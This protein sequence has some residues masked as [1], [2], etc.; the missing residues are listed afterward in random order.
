[1]RKKQRRL[2]V[3]GAGP[4]G[5]L[6][7]HAATQRGYEPIIFSNADENGQPLKSKLYG[8]QYL[9]QPIEGITAPGERVWVHYELRGS[10]EAYRRKVYGPGFQGSVSPD[11]YGPEKPHAAY[12]IRKTY[13][14]LWEMYQGRIEPATV[15]ADMA[16]RLVRDHYC[17]VLST[18]P[19]QPMCRNVA[20]I[21]Q[22]QDVWAMGTTPQRTDIPYRAPDN[23]V[24]CN[25]EDAP[26]WYRAATVFGYSTLEWPVGVKPPINGVVGVRKPLLT[27]CNCLVSKKWHRLG[28]FGK[29]RKGVL[30]HTAYLE[31]LEIL[32]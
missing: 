27:D 25:G 12:D 10:I 23:T 5:M 13:D 4:A 15:T 28:R 19:P 17:L 1:M 32:K 20:H 31:A 30:A 24:E 29:W 14:R 6:A 8:C 16:I 7:A 3:L 2:Y 11:E 9:H 21:F 22:T 18:I 26:R